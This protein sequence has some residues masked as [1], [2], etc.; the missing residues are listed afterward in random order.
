MKLEISENDLFVLTLHS[1]RY[2]MGR[3]STAP[4]TACEF[5][6]RFADKMAADARSQIRDEILGELGR[7]ER[8]GNTLGDK[9][10]HDEWTKCVRW[11]TD[12]CKR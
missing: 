2:A 1:V 4:S 7:A 6:Y 12:R 8:S 11:L 10:D 9:C 3:R 5:V